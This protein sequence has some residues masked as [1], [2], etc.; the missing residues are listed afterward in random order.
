MAYTYAGQWGSE[1]II[2][3]GSSGGASIL[4][5]T[6]VYVRNIDLSLADLWT[7]RTKTVAA[8]NPALTDTDGNL[9]FYADPGPYLVSAV[10]GGVEQAGHRVQVPIDPAEAAQDSEVTTAVAAE[11]TDRMAAD[12]L[13]I[14][15][16]QKAA[17]NGVATLGADTKV[18][19]AQ[20]P[21]IAISD[22]LGV[23][24]SQVAML[25]LAGQKGD[26]AIRSDLSTAWIITGSDPTQLADWTEL[27]T[28][29]DAVL[30]VNGRTGTVVGLAEAA[31]VVAKALFDANTVL[32]ADADNTPAAVTMASSTILARL[33]AGG[34]VAATPAELKTLLAIAESDVTGLV[35]DLSN[36]ASVADLSSEISARQTGDNTLVPNNQTTDYSLVLADM[37]KVVE[38]DAATAKNL[39]VPTNVAQAFPVNSIVSVQQIG[40]GA[41]TIVPAGGVTLVGAVLTSAGAGSGFLLRKTATNTWSVEPHGSAASVAGAVLAKV[42]Y[43][44]ATLAD[45]TTASATFAN[46]DATNLSVTFT[47]PSSGSVVVVLSAIAE[48]G[49]SSSL[50]W[51]LRDGSGDVANTAHDLSYNLTTGIQLRFTIRIH[52][53]GLTPGQA[54][55]WRWGQARTTGG[56]TCHTYVGGS[57]ANRAAL[58]E[59]WSGNS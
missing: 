55:T 38:I 48:P 36:K 9:T 47:A 45:I 12:A 8:A 46:L 28:P 51:N 3:A 4:P 26:W 59:V 49:S 37:G 18:P 32:A 14:P 1:A 53:D 43:N 6:Q 17:A 16:T 44:P 13:L 40:A 39:T 5:L 52:V 21:D 57:T 50:A 7:D 10:I 34:I 29:V 23:V 33:A 54:Y 22:F 41:I 20:L 24:G 15:L 2:K 11:A 19:A 56:A 27:P 30:S 58:M 42:R 31:D 35:T 25:A